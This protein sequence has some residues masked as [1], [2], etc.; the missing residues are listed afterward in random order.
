VLVVE[1]LGWMAV[2]DRFVPFGGYDCILFECARISVVSR[3]SI[4]EAKEKRLIP[5]VLCVTGS[6]LEPRGVRPG[7]A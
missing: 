4:V 6:E 3:N 5:S 1:G 2:G 7:L